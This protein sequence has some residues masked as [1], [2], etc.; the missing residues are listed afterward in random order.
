MELQKLNIKVFVGEPDQVPLTTFIDIFHSWIQATDGIYYDVAD[1][2][3][4]RA[5]PGIVLVAHE[6]NIS[7]D[8]TGGRRGLLYNLK[9]PLQGSNRD[10]L[11]WVFKVTLENCRRIEEEPS[12]KGRIRFLGNEALFLIN[13]RLLAPN[14]EETFR[15][16]RPDLED[17][18]QTLY[19]G[20]NVSLE[21]STRDRRDRFGVKIKTPISFDVVTL[22][23]NLEER[24]VDVEKG[25]R[26]R[27][28]REGNEGC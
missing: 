3:H 19:V 28:G 26:T 21:P 25:A 10:R 22:L 1:Y 23:K 11:R 8:E 12:M 7:I 6:A 15:V 4:M 9:Q 2:S 20:A 24:N 14:T 5:G 17:I 18:A 13:D 16:V 27:N